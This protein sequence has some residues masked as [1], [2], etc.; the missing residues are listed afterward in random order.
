MNKF[1]I[2]SV[3]IAF[4][5][6]SSHAQSW[7]ADPETAKNRTES[8]E[9]NYL[10]KNVPDYTL[11]P[12]L[13]S[14]DGIKITTTEQWEAFR[15]EEILRTL[16]MQ[17]FGKVIGKPDQV[18]YVIKSQKDTLGNKAIKKTIHITMNKNSET[19][20]MKLWLFVPKNISGPAPTYLLVNHRGE[21]HVFPDETVESGFWPIEQIIDRGY[22]TAGFMAR[23]LDPDSNT[24]RGFDNGIHGI[25]EPEGERPSYAWGTLAAWAWGASMAMNYL[26][27]DDDINKDQV[28]V[29][30]HSRGGKTALWTGAVDQRFAMAVSNMSGCGGAALSRRKYGETVERINTRFPNWFCKNFHQYNNNE[31]ELPFDQHMLLAMMAP[32]AVYVASA[33]EDLWADPRGEFL[34]LK[35]AEE[36]YEL[37]GFSGI[38]RKEM[39]PLDTPV[40]GDRTGYHIRTGEHNMTPYDWEQFMNFT[41][42]MFDY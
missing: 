14:N 13:T 28:V 39:P 42:E 25:I 6:V 41:D 38:P 23:D 12:L 24:D 29:V 7:Q 40:T 37:Y 5:F 16:Q 35:A 34:S 9:F 30:G 36:I 8:E 4:V 22:A 1:F 18:K 31:S 32:R 19:L 27:T 21:A 33:D 3:F 26:V 20:L 17:L 15:R 11:P 10:E 2:T